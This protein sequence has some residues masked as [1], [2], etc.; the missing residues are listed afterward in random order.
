MARFDTL[1]FVRSVLL[2]IFVATTA[3]TASFA[4]GTDACTSP[5]L[6]SGLGPHAFNNSTATNGPQ[7]SVCSVTCGKDVWFRWT[8]PST[9]TYTLSLCGQASFDTVIAVYAGSGCPAG[10]ALVCNDDSCSLQ[11][12]A[13]FAA[14]SGA[15]YVFQIGSYGTTTGGSGT[16]TL[17]TAVPCS[18]AV[19]PDVIVG[20]VT[21][22]SNYTP[23]G[24]LDALSLG[25]TSCNLGDTWLNWFANVNQHPV[26]GGNLYRYKVVGGAGRFEQI[27]M[28]WLKHG[29]YAL[30]QTLCCPSCSGT[31]GTHLGVGCSDPYT[32]SRNGTQSGLGPR[33]QVN[34]DTGGY[35]YPPANPGYSGNTARRLQFLLTDVESTAGVRFFGESQYVTPDDAAAGNQD[36]NAS[37]REL[38]VSG[39]STNWSFAL[40]GA[41]MRAQPAVLAWAQCESGVTLTDV[42][43]PS[44]GHLVL[45]HKV[46]ALG[47]GQYRYEYALYNMNSDDSVRSFA[48][49]IPAG[50]NVTNIGFHDVPYRNG[51]GPGNV[52][53]DGTDWSSSL[54]GGV[55]RWSTQTL[56]QNASANALRWGSTYNFR[57]DANIAPA[58]G[59]LTLG[60]FKSGG[61][62][63]VTTS[64]PGSA[65]PDADGDGIPD[66]SDNCPM[67][68]NANQADADGDAIGDACDTCTDTDGDGFSDPGFPASTCPLDLCPNDPLKSAPG[69]CGCGVP[70]TDTD[71]DGTPNCNDGC[72][73][74]PLKIAPGTCGCGTPDTDTDGDGTPNCNDGCPNDPLK[75]APG[76]CGC[77]TP[78]TDTDGDGTADCNDG[79]PNDPLKIAPGTCGCGVSDVDTDGDGVADCID[80]CVGIPNSS[81]LDQDGDTVG[82][83][84]DNCVAVGN[85]GQGDC[86]GD[87]IGDA[88]AIAAGDPDCNMNGI[89]DACDLASGFSLDLNATG[90][91]D[92]CETAAV[93][94]CFGD[95]SGTACPCGNSSAP[96]SQT[97]CLSSLG[98]GGR[99]STSG[100]PQLTADTFV[101]LGTQMP[102]SSALYFQGTTSLVGGMG[103]VFGDGLRCAGGSILRLGTKN[104]SAG[105]SQYPQGGDPTVSVRGL[106]ASPGT[107]TYQVWYRNAAA[108]CTAS[109]FNLTNGVVVIWTP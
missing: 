53:Y 41:T 79:C 27:G 33:W 30:S 20:D 76:T 48:L 6:V 82:D 24:T 67:V 81:Q 35:T 94:F 71:G 5:T 14:T 60:K 90:V 59:T 65:G 69:A 31:D 68:P 46:T 50:V 105:A 96:G 75:I 37:W 101:L 103:A 91:P 1:S 25:T 100:T 16:F 99:L 12:S 52:D 51:D 2:P 93:P 15:S 109:T 28:S 56:A 83:A 47:G 29:F 10:A 36:N 8:A 104:N 63:A 40:T 57:F 89:P 43:F 88:C 34:A 42:D 3:A 4:Q 54:S 98:I 21:G 38:S 19:G 22:P 39:N 72:P 85:P 61:S 78:D 62:A 11:S 84:C 97:G 107:R 73:N 18:A 13:D 95:G 9:A 7:S 70:D 49:P 64:V 44:E 66:A 26:I 106:V 102:N 87:L 17:S 108:F 32:S 74:D 45:G 77:G 92:E 23:T 55:L 58:S 86:D 80:N